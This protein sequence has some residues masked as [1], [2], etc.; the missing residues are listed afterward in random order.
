MLELSNSSHLLEQ[1]SY[2]YQLQDVAEPQLYRDAFSYEEAPKIPFNHRRVPMNMPEEIWITDTTFRDGQQSMEPFSVQ[3]I[4]DLYKLMSRLSGPKGI[5]RQTEFFIYSKKDREALD[6]CRELGLRFPE[7][8]SWIRATPQDFKLVADMGIPETGILVSCSDYH[9]FKKLHMTRRQA[10]DT[11][12]ATVKEAFAAGVIPR[13]HLEDITRA[14]F[15]GFVVPFVNALQDLSRE[16]GIPVK[17]RD[18]DTLGLGVPYGGSTLPR[19]VPGIIYGLR[20]YADVPAR[21]LEWHGHNDFHLATANAGHAW[22]YGASAVNCTLLCIGERTGNVPLE[23][24]VFQYAGFRGTLDGMDTT[25]ITDI[26]RYFKYQIGYDIPENTPFVG[27]NF[28]VTRAGIHADGLLKDEEIYNIFDT[29]RLLNRPASVMIGKTS[30]LAGIAY[31][32]NDNYDLTGDA[33]I[34]KNDPLVAQLK[35]WVDEEYENGRQ[36]TLGRHELEAK[37]QEFAPGRFQ[38]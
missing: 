24:M 9:I 19:C 23:S 38:S 16:A 22:M 35:A 15:Y 1:K 17:I 31:W 32:I 36:S 21:C 4:V 28:N 5:I 34:A 11:Y 6:K 3:Q 7:I 10:M 27:R 30:G 8:T 2:K 20:H 25:A 29:K 13:C 12:L 37:V 18:C 14:D 33:A 26:A